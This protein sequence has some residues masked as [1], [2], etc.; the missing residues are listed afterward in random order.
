MAHSDDWKERMEAVEQ[1]ERNFADLPDKEQAWNE[2]LALTENED[3]IVRWDATSALGVALRYISDKRQGTTHLLNLIEY[4]EFYLK[5]GATEAIGS[6]FY[7]LTD[8]EQ[9]TKILISLTKNDN[10]DLK[11][12]ATFSLCQAFPHVT[13]KEQALNVLLT[14]TKDA[15]AD[16]RG[17]T[18]SA[19]NRAF[20]Y[21]IDKETATKALLKL[22]KDK[23]SNVIAEAVSTIGQVYFY[24]TCKEQVWKDLLTL[25]KDED[26]NVRSEV[27]SALGL[28]YLHVIDKEKAL[29]D[30]LAL[31]KN[32]DYNIRR[33]AASA[34]SRAYPYVTDKELAW[35]ALLALAKDKN[36]IVRSA[37][38]WDFFGIA[39]YF[40]ENKNYEQAYKCFYGAL[41]KYTLKEYINPNSFYHLCRG[42]GSYYHGRTV[43]NELFNIENPTEYTKSL[44]YAIKLFAKSIKD[45]EKS[46]NNKYDTRFFPICLNIYSAYYEYNLSFQ[47]SDAKR[48]A[49]VKKYLDEASKQCQIIG[50]EKGERIVKIFEKL[51]E[52]LTS[53]LEEI[54]LET[55]KNKVNGIGKKAEYEPFIDKSREAFEKHIAE[56]LKSLDEIELPIIKEIAEHERIKLDNL[57][58]DKADKSEPTNHKFLK[59]VAL[60]LGTP[61]VMLTVS[62]LVLDYMGYPTA[63]MYSL[64]IFGIAFIISLI[65]YLIKR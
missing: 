39:E 52:A 58:P 11:S 18:A 19:F 44:K 43:V 57:K 50:T 14:M 65:I 30:L 47:N 34:L 28:A 27:A 4:D 21:V 8:K 12:A 55:N 53:R 5:I 38:K 36:S 54:E 16:V 46:N 49:K 9:A 1:L 32:D 31:T 62:Y 60:V 15:D 56:L 51:A 23:D 22:T 35:E 7:Y 63:R 10:P 6:A 59:A 40:L 45:I 48:V 33:E 61:T 42:L 17:D 41:T 20:P 13:D 64:I 24:I 26:Y 2:L 25:I 37:V 3:D 29:K